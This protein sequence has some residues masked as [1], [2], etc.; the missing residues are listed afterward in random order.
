MMRQAPSRLAGL[1][2]ATCK[3]CHLVS[4]SQASAGQFH[5]LALVQKPQQVTL[6]PF[7]AAVNQANDIEPFTLAG[8]Y[9]GVFE[10][11]SA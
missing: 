11:K 2:F 10:G 5:Q 1:D 9:Q 7:P 6:N 3:H 8:F 4:I